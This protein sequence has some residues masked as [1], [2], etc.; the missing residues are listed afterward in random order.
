[1]S[2]LL[3]GQASGVPAEASWSTKYFISYQGNRDGRMKASLALRA[4]Y[5]IGIT[6]LVVVQ[7][8]RGMG[9]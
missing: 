3:E 6:I 7:M 8:I 2:S 9:S 4:G 1:M 5:E